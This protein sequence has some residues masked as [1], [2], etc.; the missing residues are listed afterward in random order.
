MLV[1][2]GHHGK[3]QSGKSLTYTVGHMVN[4][5]SVVNSP[6]HASTLALGLS[7]SDDPDTME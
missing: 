3:S 7:L 1:L 4:C 6:N 2:S 5:V